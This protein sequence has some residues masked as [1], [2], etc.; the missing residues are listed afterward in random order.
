[1][2]QYSVVFFIV[3]LFV[4]SRT[5]ILTPEH[6]TLVDSSIFVCQLLVFLLCTLDN[7]EPWMIWGFYLSP[8]MYGQNAI[9]INEFLDDRWSKVNRNLNNEC[10]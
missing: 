5:Q 3:F 6:V 10:G 7:V 9:V 1:M 4:D 2:C 8:M